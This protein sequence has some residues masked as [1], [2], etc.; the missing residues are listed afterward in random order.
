LLVGLTAHFPAVKPKTRG[1]HK[2][3]ITKD[4]NL[5]LVKAN[6]NKSREPLDQFSQDATEI[7]NQTDQKEKRRFWGK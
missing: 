2:S 3:A 7:R 6:Y 5:V 1:Q 4:G